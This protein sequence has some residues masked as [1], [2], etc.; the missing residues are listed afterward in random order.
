M[1][2]DANCAQ[3]KSWSSEALLADHSALLSVILHLLPG[4][5][6]GAVSVAL[7]PAVVAGG[8]PPHVA[9]VLSIPLAMIPV[10]L[11]IL[12]YLGS[13]GILSRPP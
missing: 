7:L 3:I 10:Q 2:L 5:M 13:T 1:G 12:L 9:L 6:T 8:Y 4:V 11:G